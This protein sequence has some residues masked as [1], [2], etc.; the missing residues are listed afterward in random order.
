[1]SDRRDLDAGKLFGYNPMTNRKEQTLAVT[2]L[3]GK[4]IL[5]LAMPIL[6][7][8][9]W[10]APGLLRNTAA[11]RPRELPYLAEVSAP[12]VPAVSG[13]PTATG[14][15]KSSEPAKSVP[16]G[17]PALNQTSRIP[18]LPCRPDLSR[19]L[20]IKA[21]IKKYA[22][23]HGVEEDLVWAVIRQESGFDPTAVSPK[24][25]LGLMQLMPDTAAMMGVTN[26]FDV[27][28]N[29]VGGIKYLKNC[30]TR[31]NGDMGLALA[32]YNAGP[33]NVI[34][35]QGCPPFPETQH[36]VAA[37]LQ[38]YSGA[39]L[40]RIE[41]SPLPG[42]SPSR[43]SVEAPADSGLNWNLPTPLVKVPR[44]HWHIPQPRW[45]VITL[46]DRLKSMTAKIPVPR[47]L[48]QME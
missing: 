27:E 47:D 33:E 32:A 19:L 22:R 41:R 30:L 23:A 46:S 39:A 26:P 14:P 6:L 34:K 20:E 12:L 36:Y 25:A 38:D 40:P 3:A 18:R 7:W 43:E 2:G 8:G 24:G 10:E 21:A 17:V 16:T 42:G 15:Q 29:I 1:M 48:D 31:F 9:A 13:A 35:Y 37:V 5:A 4:L 44:P 28:Q 11:D 45:K